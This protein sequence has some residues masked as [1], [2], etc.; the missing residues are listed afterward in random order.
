M[1]II[2]IWQVYIKFSNN[3][4]RDIFL[5]LHRSPHRVFLSKPFDMNTGLYVW[6]PKLDKQVS[7]YY[8]ILYVEVYLV[9]GCQLVANNIRTT[10]NIGISPPQHVL[11]V[12]H[13][14]YMTNIQVSD[15]NLSLF[16]IN[17][18][19]NLHNIIEFIEETSYRLINKFVS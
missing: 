9:K 10:Y 14:D 18:R 11:F 13:T 5:V 7:N 16:T 4:S 8:I 12:L 15:L 17:I 3:F 6:F 2:I 19:E 1:N